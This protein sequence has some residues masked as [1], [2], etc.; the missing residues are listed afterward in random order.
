MPGARKARVEPAA[1]QRDEP[2]VGTV[3]ENPT[4]LPSL[5]CFFW[6]CP[7]RQAAASEVLRGL[8][9]SAAVDAGVGNGLLF[10]LSCYFGLGPGLS[11]DRASKHRGG[12]VCQQRVACWD[13]ECCFLAASL[14][15]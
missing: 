8:C 15:I 13:L 10:M 4:C 5:L 9:V 11:A 7:G 1:A 12:V 14:Q 3:E 6:S 2:E